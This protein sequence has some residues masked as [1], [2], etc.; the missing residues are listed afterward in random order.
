MTS[1]S[2]QPLCTPELLGDVIMFLCFP[3]LIDVLYR[4]FFIWDCLN[5]LVLLFPVYI[6]DSEFFIPTFLYF[7]KLPNSLLKFSSVMLTFSSVLLIFSSFLLIFFPLCCWL[8][9]LTTYFLIAVKKILDKSNL[10]NEGLVWFEGYCSSWWRRHL[11]SCFSCD[12]C[13]CWFE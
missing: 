9:P 8:R 6:L 5:L 7:L 3:S 4:T 13:I 11:A 2:S 12:L 1:D 10:M